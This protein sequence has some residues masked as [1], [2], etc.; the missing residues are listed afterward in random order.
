MSFKNVEDYKQLQ[1]FNYITFLNKES[2]D[3]RLDSIFK[4]FRK[5]KIQ[6]FINNYIRQDTNISV[7]LINKKERQEIKNNKSCL[8]D[9]NQEPQTNKLYYKFNTGNNLHEYFTYDKYLLKKEDYNISL[10]KRL[11]RLGLK[12]VKIDNETKNKMVDRYGKD[13]SLILNIEK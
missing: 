4:R 9:G 7:I 5:R 1:D 3:L 8:F 13:S 10:M 11:T 2:I 6:N 12:K